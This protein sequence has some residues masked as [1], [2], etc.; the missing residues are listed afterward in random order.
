VVRIGERTDEPKALRNTGPVAAAIESALL[1]TGPPAQDHER[2]SDLGKLVR[3]SLD[4]EA[5]VATLELHDAQRFNT[6]SWALGDDMRRAVRHLRERRD[7][8]H[9]VAMQGAG[10]V[11]CAGGNPYGSRGPPK[12]VAAL[13]RHM[14]GSI[15]VR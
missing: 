6:M 3:L 14:L 2:G 5:G 1:A 15:Q 10:S 9:A 7:E 12:S 8:I 13:A 11:F 4:C